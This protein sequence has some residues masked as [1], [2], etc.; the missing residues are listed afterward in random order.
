LAGEA[1]FE[2]TVKLVSRNLERDAK[3]PPTAPPTTQA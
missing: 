1:A 3:N 2:N